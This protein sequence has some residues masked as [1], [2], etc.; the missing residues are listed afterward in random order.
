MFPDVISLNF[1]L[2]L[3]AYNKRLQNKSEVKIKKVEKIRLANV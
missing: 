1:T 3:D 2:A